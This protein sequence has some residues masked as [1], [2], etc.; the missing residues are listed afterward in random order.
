[1]HHNW[2]QLTTE[3]TIDVENIGVDGILRKI[4]DFIQTYE[5]E[6]EQQT[7]TLKFQP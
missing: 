3:A 2:S 6:H 4:A 7:P 1:M 5:E